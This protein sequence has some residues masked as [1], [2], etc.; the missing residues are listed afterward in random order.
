MALNTISCIIQAV[1]H[2][3]AFFQNVFFIDCAWAALSHSSELFNRAFLSG[4]Q[5]TSVTVP[6]L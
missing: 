2:K 4:N 6:A 5:V 1:Q 3:A